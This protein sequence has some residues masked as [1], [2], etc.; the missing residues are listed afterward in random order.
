MSSGYSKSPLKRPDFNDQARELVA[1][2]DGLEKTR[3]LATEYSSKAL[4]ALHYFPECEERVALEKLTRD[5][6]IRKK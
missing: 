1:V 3:E 5:V 2:S 4:E 6:L